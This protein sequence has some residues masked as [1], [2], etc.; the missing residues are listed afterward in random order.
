VPVDA[1]DAGYFGRGHV[2]LAHA[3]DIGSRN[4]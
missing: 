2:V 1:E 4:H 3:A